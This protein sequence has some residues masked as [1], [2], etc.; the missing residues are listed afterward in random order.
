NLNLVLQTLEITNKVIVVLNLMDEALKKHI[1][2]DTKKLA[3]LL[4]VE[5]VPLNARNQ[6]G[7]EAVKEAI[8]RV[9][10][11]QE[12]SFKIINYDTDIEQAILKIASTIESNTLNKRFLALKF[13]DTSVENI[14]F[15]DVVKNSEH[16][17][18]Q[19]A[20]E[21]N[22]L[23]EKHKIGSYEE[24][25]VNAIDKKAKDIS[26]ACV[27]FENLKYQSRDMKIDQHV[28]SKGFGL[29]WMVVLLVIVFWITISGANLPSEM[30]STMFEHMEE[31]MHALFIQLQ[32]TPILS[33]FVID[34][35]FKTCS[36][37]VA[38]ML[39]PMA[40]FF[41]LFTLLEDFGYLPRIAFNLDG[42]FQKAGACGKQALT[43]CMGFGCNAVGVSGTRI[44]DSPRERLLAIITNV[45]VPCNGRFPTLI[46]ILTM[47]FAGMFIKPWN[48]IFSTFLLTSIVMFGIF[49]T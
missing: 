14:M 19:C 41:P 42:F 23:K 40:I 15:Y 46:S 11:K 33:A 21:R 24:T 13:L 9:G 37:V 28:T 20:R 36:W 39:P 12:N 26:K 5:V 49:L 45:F 31:S 48:T 6:V 7:F 35:V 43:M 30:L 32:V 34:G 3:L 17:A 10:K 27:R 44:I 47:F 25:L 2:I 1:H 29:L 8:V 38:V 18:K 16:I 22:I 4:G